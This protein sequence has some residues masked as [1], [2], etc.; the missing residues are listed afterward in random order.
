METHPLKQTGKGQHDTLKA[1]YAH[2]RSATKALA[3]N[4]SDADATVQ[5]MEE[6]SPAKWHLAHVSW[7]F[8]EVIL[9]AHVPGY[10]EFDQKYSFLFNSYY[11]AVGE[12]QPRPKRGMLTR[13]S[14]QEVLGYRAHVDEQMD[15]LL[16]GGVNTEARALV[17]LGL[18]HEEQ[19]QELLLTDILHLFAQNPLKPAFRDPG[20]LAYEPGRVLASGYTAFAG[21]VMEF[22]AE[23][24]GAFHFDCEAPRH[25]ELVH[26]FRLANGPVTGADWAAFIKDG[27]Y[28]NSLLWL[29]DGWAVRQ[30][31]GWQAPLYWEIRQG[32]WWAM[33]LRGMQPVDM[34][35][36]VCHVSYYEAD[37]YATWANKR[38]PSE[39]ELELA[40]RNQKI[41]GNFA[42]SG[43]LRP[44][45]VY[46]PEGGGIAGLY[47]DVWQWTSS[48]FA[49]YRGFTPN[50]GVVGEYNGK[51]MSGQQ[52]LRGGSCST[53]EGHMRPTYRNFW[54]PSTRWQFTGLRLAEDY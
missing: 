34:D 43:R 22:G 53:P 48:S 39:F 46:A 49:P 21:G 35:A 44:A 27:G 3:A 24:E 32:N 14:L 2:V 7:F 41:E 54:H 17:E 29:S 1:R 36:P 4:L 13:P 38:L 40:A 18:N 31:E 19:H 47:G 28:E 52:V 9:K 37:A 42:S 26:P 33:T 11:D 45:P 8:E 16:A 10:T 5:S 23:T 50:E 30:A 12:R 15:R 51:F 6:A 20:P 25:E